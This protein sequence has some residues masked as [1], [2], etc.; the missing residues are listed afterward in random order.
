MSLP[1]V[2]AGAAVTVGVATA[3]AVGAAV[4]ADVAFADAAPLGLGRA[5]FPLRDVV[6]SGSPEGPIR[7]NSGWSN[8]VPIVTLP[9]SLSAAIVVPSSK[10]TS[11]AAGEVVSVELPPAQPASAMA[12]AAAS[13][14]GPASL[15]DQQARV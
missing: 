4:G 3:V 10:V 12:P 2:A 15:G 5:D 14:H 8:F 11:S 6:P 1:Y 7:P 13:G 9:A